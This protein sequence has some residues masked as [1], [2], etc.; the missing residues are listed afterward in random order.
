[1]SKRTRESKKGR[2]KE[3]HSEKSSPGTMTLVL[4]GVALVAVLVVG[5]NLFASATDQT[6][7]A[8]LELPAMTP[9]EMAELAQ[10]VV[11]GDDG[12][13]LTI[14][15]FSDYSCPSCRQFASA[16]KPLLDQGY[17]QQGLARFA[18]YD[19]PLPGFPNSFLA[20][21]A[22]RCAGDQDGY[23]PFHD[24]LFRNQPQWSIMA[25]PVPTFEGYAERL[26]LDRGDYRSCLRSDRHAEVVTANRD[27]GRQLG[28]QGTPTIFVN[29]GEG[30]AL[31]VEDWGNMTEVR[32]ILDEA[33]VRLGYGPTQESAEAEEDS[34]PEG[35]AGR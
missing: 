6:V 15:D 12:A 17:V 25:D 8:P 26:G 2:G 27:L 7:R 21:R 31:R 30:R 32:R 5:W 29:T 9:Q 35:G 10:P 14:M 11:A 1:V 28:V 18:Y 23:W 4:G 19:F 20:A 13:P 33:L 16:V 22:A 34:P 3:G 24:E